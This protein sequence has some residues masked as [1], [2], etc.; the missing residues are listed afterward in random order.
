MLKL[1]I[2]VAGIDS[3]SVSTCISATIKKIEE[4]I[5]CFGRHIKM[6]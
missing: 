1:F 3:I 4:T 5:K 6:S 2:Y